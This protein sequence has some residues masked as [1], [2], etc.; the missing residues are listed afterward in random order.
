MSIKRTKYLEDIRVQIDFYQGWIKNKFK[1]IRLN[2]TSLICLVCL[3][4]LFITFIDDYCMDR[5]GLLQHQGI[6]VHTGVCPWP[7]DDDDVDTQD[8]DEFDAS[9]LGRSR[10]TFDALFSTSSFDFGTRP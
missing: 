3:F 4:D 9:A 5:T 10:R 1:E 7:V 8:L 2:T 6:Q